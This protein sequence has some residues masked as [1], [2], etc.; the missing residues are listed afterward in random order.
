[1]TSIFADVKYII[2]WGEDGGVTVYGFLIALGILLGALFGYML[3]KKRNYPRD[4]VI[5]MVLWCVPL[6]VVGARLYY[7]VFSAIDG[8]ESWTFAGIFGSFG[9]G[10]AIFGAV[11]FSILGAYLLSIYYKKRKKPDINDINA[12]IDGLELKAA[13]VQAEI[14]GLSAQEKK[15]PEIEQKIAALNAKKKKLIREKEALLDSLKPKPAFFQ[16]ADLGAPFLILGQ[17]LGRIG[18]YFSECCYGNLINN[19]AWQKAPFAVNID[20]NWHLATYFLESAWCLLGFALM[21]YFS[22]RK[23]K[24]RDSFVFSFYLMFY[25]VGRFV[26]EFFRVDNSQTLWLVR[27]KLPISMLVAALMFAWGAYI[28]IRAFFFKKN[29]QAP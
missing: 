21:I 25:G 11:L 4:M 19:P 27:D 28:M 23:K 5:D 18:C 2:R 9:Q 22:L 26:L 1:M 7:V 6:A 12:K 8:S 3:S 14:D 24:P 15:T 20:G 13:G 29:T 16:M 17:A 10:L